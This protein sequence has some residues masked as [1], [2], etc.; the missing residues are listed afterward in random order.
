MQLDSYMSNAKMGIEVINIIGANTFSKC[1]FIK[2]S[3]TINTRQPTA[4][5]STSQN[6]FNALRKFGIA[7]AARIPIMATTINSS[8]SVNPLILVNFC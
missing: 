3:N 2:I 5:I 1:A 6:R 7:I 8:I 4:A